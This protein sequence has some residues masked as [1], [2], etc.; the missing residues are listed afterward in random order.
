MGGFH[1]WGYPSSWMVYHEE[2]Y[3]KWMI[4]GYPFARMALALNSSAMDGSNGKTMPKFSMS[5]K[6]IRYLGWYLVD[7]PT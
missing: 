7:H 4:C 3:Y 5:I 6:T 1:K 2:I